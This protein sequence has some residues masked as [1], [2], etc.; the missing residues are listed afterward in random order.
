MRLCVGDLGLRDTL[1][2]DGT[3]ACGRGWVCLV[4]PCSLIIDIPLVSVQRLHVS[5]V[6]QI[7]HLCQRDR[8]VD[9]DNQSERSEHRRTL[10]P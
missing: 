8:R 4:S 7:P 6:T 5:H 2:G 1:R 9:R 3:K 10:L